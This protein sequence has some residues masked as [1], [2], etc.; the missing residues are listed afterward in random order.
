MLPRCKSSRQHGFV[1]W[2]SELP[3]CSSVACLGKDELG[4]TILEVATEVRVEA[5]GG[6][7]RGEEA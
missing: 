6:T 5:Q 2:V 4:F 7:E 3:L 1:H